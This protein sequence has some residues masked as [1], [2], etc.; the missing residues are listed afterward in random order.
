[1]R[2]GWIP[3]EP[4][5]RDWPLQPLM[6]DLRFGDPSGNEPS[7]EQF[8]PNPR[9]R[10]YNYSTCTAGAY[11]TGWR[12]LRAAEGKPDFDPST[13][14]IYYN[15]RRQSGKFL[16]FHKVD[17][18]AYPR[19][20]AKAAA[21][22]GFGPE[23]DWPQQANHINKPPPMANVAFGFSTSGVSYYWITGDNRVDQIDFA[24]RNHWPICLGTQVGDNW[25]NYRGIQDGEL[26]LP[27]ENKG[28]HYLLITRHM[29]N[30]VMKFTN[31][32]SWGEGLLSREVIK[33]NITRD[34]MVMKR[35]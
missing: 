13:F 9:Y 30:G 19:D 14:Q 12:A 27:K 28:G 17:G 33:A 8:L 22:Y 21:K 20:V 3:N 1:M 25:F 7:I 34:I 35:S 16:N 10:Q 11:K 29:G 23:E 4:D 18:G 6:D 5:S 2:F 15:G 24:L 32:W 26:G 31:W